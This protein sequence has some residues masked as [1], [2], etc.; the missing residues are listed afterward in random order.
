MQCEMDQ[1]VK[2]KEEPAWLKETTNA[3][4]E[5]SEHVSE[6]IALKQEAK[7]E[8]TEPESTQE[9]SLEPSE[10]NKKEIFIEQNTDDQLLA[11]VKEETQPRPEVS[12]TDHQPAD[13]VGGCFRRNICGKSF[14]KKLNRIVHVQTQ[15]GLKLHCCIV[16]GKSFNQ[17]RVLRDHM[18]IHSRD[19]AH[20][21]NECG[22]SF[23]RKNNLTVHMRIHTS[24]KPYW[25]NVCVLDQANIASLIPLTRPSTEMEEELQQLG[26]KL[27]EDMPGPIDILLGADIAGKIWSGNRVILSS[28][29]VAVETL[30]GWTLMGSEKKTPI[31]SCCTNLATTY[32]MTTIIDGD[33]ADLWK[34][35]A[36]GTCDPA[37]KQDR[38]AK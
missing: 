19:M 38:K 15:T 2:I 36:I 10:D 5:N 20:Y 21:C 25:C 37:E 33:I 30:S 26:F 18:Q 16:C 27:T 24:E 23:S 6:V 7:S 14:S 3:S 17:K 29:V 31:A 13:D 9:N 11:Y 1:E 32:T 12:C 28:G 35:E 4:L 34:L 22:K 8:L